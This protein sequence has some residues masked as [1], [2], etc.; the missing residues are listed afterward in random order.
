MKNNKVLVGM[1]GGVDSSVAAALLIQ[2]GFDVTGLTITPFKIEDECRKESFERS[3]CN[4]KGVLDAALVCERLGI[5]HV[6]MDMS[7]AFKA[8]VVD[9]FVSEYLRGR[10]PNPCVVCNPLIKWQGML[11]KAD[12]IG[13]FYAATGHYAKICY[14]EDANRYIL[15]K[16]IDPLKDQSYFLWRLS[17][18]QLERTLFPLG[19]LTKADIR[20]IAKELELP[21]FDKLESQEVCFINDN[22]YRSFL[23]RSIPDIDER[24]GKGSIMLGDK[25]IGKHDG[26]PFYT[27][28]QRKGLGVPHSEPLYIKKI[29]AGTNSI[30]VS[31][32]EELY[33]TKLRASTVNCV[34]RATI[35]SDAVYSVKIRYRDKGAPARCKMIDDMLEVEFLERRRAIT[36][37]QSVVLYLEDELICG[38]IIESSEL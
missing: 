13:A 36:P 7:E 23:R 12:S 27:I 5:E 34:S 37:G 22:D 21:V 10:T 32:R 4:Y 35:D 24:I 18:K 9:N 20:S 1:S 3:C 8:K 38:G 31:V 17:Q 19:E 29:N 25:E 2:Q 30:E 14:Y 6:L 28:G 16:G 26:F 11:A 15:K 33:T